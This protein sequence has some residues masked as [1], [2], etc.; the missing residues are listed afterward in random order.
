MAK[1]CS[2]ELRERVIE[3]VEMGAS[4]R[5][6]AELYDGSASSAIKWAQRRRETG[7]ATAK[8]HGGAFLRWTSSVRRFWW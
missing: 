2:S 3:A 7:R 5:E 8:P 1:A 4:R 6:A